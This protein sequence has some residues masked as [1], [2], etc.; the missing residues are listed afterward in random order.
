[1]GG[2]AAI[3]ERD[4][5]DHALLETFLAKQR[6]SAIEPEHQ[7]QDLGRR[8]LRR[9]RRSLDHGLAGRLSDRFGDGGNIGGC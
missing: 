3:I 5:A 2:R 1:M 6:T 4:G 7:A 8:A 9:V